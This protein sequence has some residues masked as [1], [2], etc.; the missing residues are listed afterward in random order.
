MQ[1]LNDTYHSLL[2]CLHI[3]RLLMGL[4]FK[5]LPQQQINMTQRKVKARPRIDGERD[6]TN[7]SFLFV[8]HCFMFSCI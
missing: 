3:V 1:L 6:I 7:Y 8:Q 4:E 2:L 5:R